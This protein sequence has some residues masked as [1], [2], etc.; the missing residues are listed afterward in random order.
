MKVIKYCTTCQKLRA[1]FEDQKMA[2]LR[3]DRV[4]M[5]AHFLCSAVDYF[6]PFYIRHGRKEIKRYGVTFT[7]LASEAIHLE[8]SHTMETYLFL[9][10]YRRFVS[11]RGPV[12]EQ[13]C[14]RGTNFC[15]ASSELEKCL[16][17]WTN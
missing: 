1:R 8:V 7:C 4:E 10:A 13:R 15:G 6:G 5:S 9:N 17:K 12:K 16:K 2:D 11:G 14:D 3:K